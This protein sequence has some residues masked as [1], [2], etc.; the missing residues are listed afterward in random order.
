MRFPCSLF[1]IVSETWSPKNETVF[2]WTLSLASLALITFESA[3]G[4]TKTALTHKT[5]KFYRVKSM[6]VRTDEFQRRI[7]SL[8][9]DILGVLA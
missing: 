7:G 5:F 8:L 6:T 4:K 3:S 2:L 1:P 9:T